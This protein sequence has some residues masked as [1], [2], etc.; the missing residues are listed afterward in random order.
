MSFAHT[1]D[2]IRNKSKTVTRRKGWEFLKPGD[3]LNA[4]VKCM[5]LKPGETIERLCMIEVTRVRRE[6]LD[7]MIDFPIYGVQEAIREGFPDMNG[8]QFVAMFVSN[9]G[10]KENQHI[11]RIEFKYV[12]Q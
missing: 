2:Q 12:D 9:M 8:E 3:Q 10:G 6:P 11:T 1:T 7:A 4:C 5:G